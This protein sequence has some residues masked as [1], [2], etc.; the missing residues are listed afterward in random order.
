MALPRTSC[1][2]WRRLVAQGGLTAAGSGEEVVRGIGLSG[3]IIKALRRCRR[4]ISIGGLEP[5]RALNLAA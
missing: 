2:P 5:D 3:V 4:E 1:S